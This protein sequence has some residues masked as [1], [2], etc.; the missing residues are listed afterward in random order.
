M[1]SACIPPRVR[2]DG[3]HRPL[4]AP[5]RKDA[6]T[7]K[8]MRIH[9]NPTWYFSDYTWNSNTES[10]QLMIAY[11]SRFIHSRSIASRSIARMPM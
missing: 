7:T 5:M 2:V 10:G 8:I 11:V 3:P 9:T 6:S 1:S 4:A